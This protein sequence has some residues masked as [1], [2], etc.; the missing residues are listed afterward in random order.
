M[1]DTNTPETYTTTGIDTANT[2][3]YS[4]PFKLVPELPLV[5]ASSF[6][7]V[8]VVNNIDTVRVSW[9]SLTS[10]YISQTEDI[11]REP[12]IAN[13]A[14]YITFAADSTGLYISD[15]SMWRKAP[16]YG[17]NWEDL[18]DDT[19][20][21]LVNAP[22]ELTDAEVNN[23]RTSLKLG[24]AT[25]TELGL[26]KVLP[27]TV[28][29]VQADSVKIN[30]DGVLVIDF[31]TPIEEDS[32]EGV[33]GV[34]RLKNYYSTEVTEDGTYAVTEKYVREAIANYAENVTLPI[35]T[36]TSL[37]AVI[38]DSGTAL[39]ISE[40]GSLS[41]KSATSENAGV[42][43]LD[44]STDIDTAVDSHA[45]SVGFVN[46][47]LE[48]K[49]SEVYDKVAGVNLG[50]VRVP[51]DTAITIDGVG[52]IDVRTATETYPG[53]VTVL[54]ALD[55]DG[56]YS[57]TDTGSTAVTPQAVTE[58]VETKLSSLSQSL[59]IATAAT[60][61]A[62]RVGSSVVVDEGTGVL[63]I[64]NATPARL[65]GVYVSLAVND[66]NSTTVPT[67]GR[68]LELI[69]NNTPEL[70]T[71]KIDRYGTVKLSLP[72]VIEDGAKIGVNAY[73]QIVAEKTTTTG[74][75]GVIDGEIGI[76]TKDKLGLVAL[77]SSNTVGGVHS[78]YG[79]PIGSNEDGSIYVDAS[80]PSSYATT[81]RPGLVQLSVS[82]S[83]ILPTTN[84]GIGVD[85]NGQLRVKG[86]S[87]GGGGS[88]TSDFN[89]YFYKKD[90][91][92]PGEYSPVY[93]YNSD[94]WRMPFVPAA[95]AAYPGV[96]RLGTS[97]K[98]VGGFPVGVNESGTL[99]VA[100]NTTGDGTV[101]GPATAESSG[102]VKLGQDD[103]I[104]NGLRVGV[105][106]NGQLCVAS[107]ST[108]M[109]TATFTLAGAVTLST[110]DT[111]AAGTFGV[112]GVDDTNG[113]LAVPAATSESYGVVKV[114]GNVLDTSDPT[115]ALVGRTSD[116][117]L[118]VK[119]VSSGGGTVIQTS[120]SSLQVT[121]IPVE[122]STTDYIV[123]MTGGAIQL[124]DGNIVNIEAITEEDNIVITPSSNQTL[125][126]KVFINSDGEPVAKLTLNSSTKVLTCKPFMG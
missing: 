34:V 45:A 101:V 116:G 125:S 50:M 104:E 7:I 39:T 46:T 78:G 56:N 61:G 57:N 108:G 9:E 107:T 54:G 121:L 117:Q 110:P 80:N 59:P 33:P 51:G 90:E 17:N 102:V 68:V 28:D 14:P 2:S 124:N 35:A 13:N 118:A 69:N 4:V 84:P 66:V 24:T 79:L 18:T 75:G 38:I 122:G 3:I 91:P 105:N 40:S 88:S 58:Y 21:L 32:P 41:I 20:F 94:T 29:A 103:V 43:F 19:R 12:G 72:D 16:S 77:S 100:I 65:G 10:K 112:V 99:C 11:P 73:G 62:I 126:L 22:M 42:V 111:Y 76:A 95:S 1:S 23:A 6:D 52:N 85:A 86:S 97:T 8:A 71:A 96:V 109:S 53:A 113:K 123:T 27:T 115:V 36:E 63:D 48:R 114:G 60:L 83:E 47:V 15:G 70:N 25:D 30:N 106:A 44:E 89:Y 81:V 49:V 93:Y 31:A 67:E 98:V 64:T 82:R 37:G 87:S 26:V 92:S 55:P 5:G 74:G 119:G 120:D